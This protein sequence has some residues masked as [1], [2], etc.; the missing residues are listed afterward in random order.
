MSRGQAAPSRIRW[1]L[2]VSMYSRL[3]A[4]Y[5]EPTSPGGTAREVVRSPHRAPAPSRCVRDRADPE[6]GDRG[7]RG[8]RLASDKPLEAEPPSEPAET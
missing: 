3:A 5:R 8:S 6:V 7:A 1:I 4:M 2:S